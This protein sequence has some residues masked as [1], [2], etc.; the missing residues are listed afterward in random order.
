MKIAIGIL[1]LL[2]T[3]I[4]LAAGLGNCPFL[5]GTYSCPQEQGG[6]LPE[7]LRI[8]QG[9][10][11]GALVYHFSN[12]DIGMIADGQPREVGPNEE[13]RGIVSF[14]CET[15]TLV[16]S[17]SRKVMPTHAYLTLYSLDATSKQNLVIKS[18]Q[19]DDGVLREHPWVDVC[20]RQ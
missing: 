6:A 16:Q 15:G 4:S 3:Q 19:L 14:H 18:A 13:H 9:W 5:V 11:N 10:E 7:I 17:L 12:I 8:T 1:S 20:T 2:F